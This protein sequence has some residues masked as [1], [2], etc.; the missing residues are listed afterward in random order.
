VEIAAVLNNSV[1]DFPGKMAL[2]VFTQGCNRHCSHCHNADLIPQIGG[3]I[4]W[5][6]VLNLL[7]ERKSWIDAVVFTGGEPA[8]QDDLYARMVDVV[9]KKTGIGIGLHTNGD[10]LTERIAKMCDYILLSQ[11]NREKIAIARNAGSVSLSTVKW[12]ESLG[13]YENKIVVAR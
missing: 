11:H 3:K 12:N 6:Y 7:N 9:G 5:E 8:I 1:L 4:E 2:T 10:F 13:K